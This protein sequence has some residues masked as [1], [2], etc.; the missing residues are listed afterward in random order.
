MDKEVLKGMLL[1]PVTRAIEVIEYTNGLDELYELLDCGCIDMHTLEGA[2]GT[3][4]VTFDD[5]F[6]IA[7]KPPSCM[8][9]ERIVSGGRALFVGVDDEGGNIDLTDEQIAWL[10]EHLT[11]AVNNVT[12]E[13]F[14]VVAYDPVW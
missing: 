5:E 12:G 14:P 3:L 6:R 13:I 8:Q 9:G 2:P 1:D 11:I 4:D 10:E 7:G